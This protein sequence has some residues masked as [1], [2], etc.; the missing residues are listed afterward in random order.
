MKPAPFEYER[1]A[2][3]ADALALLGR[4]G[5]EAKVLAGG[6]SLI[7]ILKLRLA[8]PPALVDINRVRE[9]DYVRVD[10]GGVAFG[11][12][13]RL[14][15]LTAASVRAR[16]PL[17]AAAGGHIGHA[18]IRHRGTVC[19]SI[20]HA[21]PAAEL[22]VVAAV[23]EAR[24]RVAG[25]AGERRVPASAFFQSFFQ[26]AVNP[27]ELL[28]ETTFPAPAPG[29]GW[30]FTELARRHGD[31]ALASVACVLEPGRDGRIARARIALGSVAD[32]PVRAAEAEAALVGTRG[33]APAREAAARAAAAPLDP[34]SDVHG[35]GAYRRH[36]VQVLVE[37]AVGEA[38]GRVGA[39]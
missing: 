19:G 37:R 21:D 15:E 34:P 12:L 7:P 14:S 16:C 30:S 2:S 31:F 5:A 3:V 36:L 29:A 4:Y 1:A 23:L 38:W 11:A 25:P 27:G 26:T 10:G 39:P 13:A 6:Q 20:A 9:L 22:P 28:V 18:A 32:R 8:R 24:M 17:L 33:E 35:S